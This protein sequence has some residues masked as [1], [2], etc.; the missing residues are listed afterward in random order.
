ME[1]P[2][3]K[4]A[5]NQAHKDLK[6]NDDKERDGN[7]FTFQEGDVAQMILDKVDEEGGTPPSTFLPPDHFMFNVVSSEKDLVE[8]VKYELSLCQKIFMFL[9]D[10]DICILAGYYSYLMM[11]TIAVSCVCFVMSSVET[12]KHSPSSCKSPACENDPTLCPNQTICEPIE[13]DY[14][15]IFETVCVIIFTVDYILRMITV[16]FVPPRLSRI[17]PR[18]IKHQSSTQQRVPDP[19]YSWYVKIW[20]YG[21]KAFNIIDFA[22]IL[23]YYLS[24]GVEVGSSL[25]ILRVLRLVRV[26]RVLKSKSIRTGLKIIQKAL[27][28]SIPALVILSFLTVLMVLLFGSLIFF[29]EGG[30]FT[31]NDEYPDGAYLRWNV[32]ESVKEQSPFS[33]IL[34]SIYWAIVTATTVGYGDFY[35]TSPLGRFTAVCLMYIGIVAIALPIS[36][37]G[38]NFDRE[39]IAVHNKKS[40]VEAPYSGTKVENRREMLQHMKEM[41]EA[42]KSINARIDIISQ[43]LLEEEEN[44]CSEAS[45]RLTFLNPMRNNAENSGGQKGVLEIGSS[46]SS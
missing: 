37:V 35:P 3:I 4:L 36:I 43:R 29:C 46:A 30:D 33:S 41:S 10:P 17:L 42:I 19:E 18:H 23:P 16:P 13:D 22:A 11:I 15:F 44:D 12:F 20:K 45:V 2:L 39:Y 26:F 5:V 28:A 40:T 24:F 14:F 25:V 9:E 8:V 1:M 27:S 32:D 31:V 6:D 38:S 21:T 34:V 7:S